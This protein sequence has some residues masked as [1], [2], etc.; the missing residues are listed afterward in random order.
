MS[1]TG[2][3]KIRSS[4]GQETDT[5]EIFADEVFPLEDIRQRY[6]RELRIRLSSKLLDQEQLTALHEAVRDHPGRCSLSLQLEQLKENAIDT[7]VIRAGEELSISPSNTL[8]QRLQELPVVLSIV[9][10]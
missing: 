2:T 3:V 6:L 10:L 8:L 9:E 7:V 4:E 5:I 1:I